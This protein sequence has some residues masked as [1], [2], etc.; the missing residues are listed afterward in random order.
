MQRKNTRE[1]RVIKGKRNESLKKRQGKL[2]WKTIHEMNQFKKIIINKENQFG[3]RERNRLNLIKK[4]RK[5]IRKITNC[6]IN[7]KEKR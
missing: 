7:Q 6:R 5:S 3:K 1:R 4:S 2:I